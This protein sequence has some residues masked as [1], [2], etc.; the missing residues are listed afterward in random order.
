M[1]AIRILN[2]K[3]KGQ[4]IPLNQAVNVIGRSPDCEIPIANSGVSKAHAQ[5]EFQN[6][7]IV[8]TDLEGTAQK[9]TKKAL[10]FAR[11]AKRKKISKDDMD[12]AI[13]YSS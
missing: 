12:L 7:K 11:H 3:Q 5:I 8:I 10:G 6:N 1:W 4:V 13:K 2:G 9:L